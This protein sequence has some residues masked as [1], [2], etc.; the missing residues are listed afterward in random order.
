MF[1]PKCGSDIPNNS[2]VCPR[3]G[4]RLQQTP[5]NP[6]NQ[7]A[8]QPVHNSQ[9]P[10]KSTLED[11]REIEIISGRPFPLA[12]I[13][14]TVL[15]LLILIITL[16]A[17]AP[18]EI[19]FPSALPFIIIGVILFVLSLGTHIT[20]TNKRVYGVALLFLSKRRVDL[21]MDSITSVARATFGNLTVA[22]SSG[23]AN[24][25]FLM[26][27]KDVHAAIC[28]LLLER[29]NLELQYKK[30]IESLLYSIA[31]K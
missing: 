7:P 3:C 6:V 28:Q 18:E 17:G 12:G 24:F 21:P 15:G 10:Q 8:V 26:N 25:G 14:I 13:V 2:V 29:E 1:C 9:A 11:L 19:A 31:K 4:V 16:A 20:V 22:T 30:N 27:G 5:S 23:R